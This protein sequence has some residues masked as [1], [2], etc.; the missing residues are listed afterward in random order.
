MEFRKVD[1]TPPIKFTEL[2]AS[3][4]TP[5]RVL[6]SNRSRLVIETSDDLCLHYSDIAFRILIWGHRNTAKTHF[7]LTCPEPICIIDTEDRF[8]LITPKFRA[9]N[10]C[11]K[12]WVSSDKH[13]KRPNKICGIK[14]CPYCESKNVRLKDIRRI[15]AVNSQQ[16]RESAKIFIDLLD[17]HYKETGKVGTIG[18]DNITKIWDWVQ[19]EYAT[20]KGLGSNDRLS[21]RDDYK[22]IN[23]EHNENFRDIILQCIHNVVFIATAKPI[24]DKE[25]QY[26]I[27]GTG[28]EGQ[29]HNPFAVDWEIYNSEG[30]VLLKDGK[31]VGNGVFSSYILKNSI[32]SG[33]IN[34]IQFLDYGKLVSIREKLLVECGVSELPK[35]E[36]EVEQPKEE[37]KGEI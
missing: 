6:V 4:S 5:G 26:K 3:A 19:N 29:K 12:Q 31:T 28:A 14:E 32:A 10:D 24:Y 23:P 8:K 15:R 25:D 7:L 34:P 30:E 22:H 20:R 13:P 36:T 2:A 33:T 9:C 11:G 37:I 27:T 35:P 17:K 16:A 21:P 1:N 18:V